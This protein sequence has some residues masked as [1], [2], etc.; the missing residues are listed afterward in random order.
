MFFEPS[1][2]VFFVEKRRG[3][4]MIILL[5][6]KM[7]KT[8]DRTYHRC[9]PSTGVRRMPETVLIECNCNSSIMRSLLPPR[10]NFP[11]FCA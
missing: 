1:V 10:L 9:V 11:R 4:S 5:D 7:K 3:L 6:K 8:D 2:T